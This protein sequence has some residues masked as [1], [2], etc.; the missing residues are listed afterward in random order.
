MQAAARRAS[1]SWSRS[2]G[3]LGRE[4]AQAAGH[5][6]VALG[7]QRPHDAREHRRQL[8]HDLG[9]GFRAALRAHARPL[10]ARAARAPG[11]ACLTPTLTL[12]A[13]R[14]AWH[15]RRRTRSC[16]TVSADTS[17]QLSSEPMKRTRSTSDSAAHVRASVME[18]GL[19]ARGLVSPRLRALAGCA[20]AVAIQ[21]H[22]TSRP[23]HHINALCSFNDLDHLLP[24]Q[25][26]QRCCHA[27]VLHRQ[28]AHAR[29]R[30][31]PDCR[32]LGRAP[33]P[34]AQE[35][36]GAHLPPRRPLLQ[37]ARPDQARIDS[38]QQRRCHA[39]AGRHGRSPFAPPQPR[40][41]SPRQGLRGGVHLSMRP[42]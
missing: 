24:R 26:A 37:N 14:P 9:Q 39:S 23:T 2:G 42:G 36:L 5:V 20:G 27:S 30:P 21:T 3:A 32:M 19:R 18:T 12:L 38:L 6:L 41:A 33:S 25:A 10:A 31:C 35:D 7:D 13:R 16:S 40:R 29:A 8:L 1:A 17:P 15:Q 34:V 11:A 4:R 22:R 28:P